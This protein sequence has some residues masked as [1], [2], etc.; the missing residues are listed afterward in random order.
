MKIQGQFLVENKTSLSI[1]VCMHFK[2]CTISFSIK[3]Q[4]I[5]C[6]FLNGGVILY[7]GGFPIEIETQISWLINLRIALLFF[8]AIK[9]QSYM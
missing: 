1:Y 8:E 9:Q 5:I 6:F 2:T 3:N 7:I 4:P